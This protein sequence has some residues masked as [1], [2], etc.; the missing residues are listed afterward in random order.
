[1]RVLI[2][3]VIAFLISI[4]GV[5]QAIDGLIAGTVLDSAGGALPGAAILIRNQET[6]AERKLTT[7]ENGRYSAVGLGVGAYQI[8]ASKEGFRTAAK[9]GISLA[10]GQRADVD[11]RLSVG[12]VR[13]TVTVIE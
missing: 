10:V 5:G 2:L 6:G 12:E 8:T 1:M 7:D 9:T 3:A 13:E 11:L 4:L